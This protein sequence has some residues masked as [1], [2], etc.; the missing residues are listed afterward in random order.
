MRSRWFSIFMYI[1]SF[2]LIFFI[3]SV[4]VINAFYTIPYNASGVDLTRSFTIAH[5][6]A[7]GIVALIFALL[8]AYCFLSV[9]GKKRLKEVFTKERKP[10]VYISSVL[11]FGLVYFIMELLIG[12][13]VLNIND[14]N[15]FINGNNSAGV[16][17]NE[18]KSLNNVYLNSSNNNINLIS[19]DGSYSLSVTDSNLINY[20]SNILSEKGL[21][22]VI[23]EKNNATFNG[24]RVLITLT[25]GNSEVAYLDNSTFRLFN[26][27][28]SVD[29][30]TSNF[31]YA[32]KAEIYANSSSITGSANYPVILR[33]G[34]TAMFERSSFVSEENCVTVF[35]VTS[36][37][38]ED[39][40]TISLKNS[41]IDKG[42]YN[43]FHFDKTTGIINLSDLKIDWSDVEKYI[44]DIESSDVTINISDSMVTGTIKFDDKSKLKINLERSQFNGTVIGDNGFELTMDDNS[45]FTSPTSIHLSKFTG[46]EIAFRKVI[47]IQNQVKLDAEI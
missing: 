11:T 31:I 12:Y 45:V 19:I 16:I 30:Y 25:G 29:N 42:D 22:N 1:L 20:G 26:S 47:S 18:D 28:V 34:T 44:A 3:S 33:N 38:K 39:V 7:F 41:S 40:N 4:I 23:Y 17:V 5:D 35:D 46:S 24:D 14:P 15:A 2:A 6:I 32:N 13:I 37:D 10:S 21:N 27:N 9:F 43:L 36:D 8:G